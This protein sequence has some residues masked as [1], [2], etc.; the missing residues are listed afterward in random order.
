MWDTL[1]YTLQRFKKVQEFSAWA[2]EPLGF[3]ET[4]NQSRIWSE[5]QER[6]ALGRA[7][8]SL[9]TSWLLDY[10]PEDAAIYNIIEPKQ[11]LPSNTSRYTQSQCKLKSQIIT[12]YYT[13]WFVIM[14]I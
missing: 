7:L 3:K 11:R 1:K 9:T 8:L 6:S 2:K 10:C 14:M 12:E 13:R 4:Q 5:Q